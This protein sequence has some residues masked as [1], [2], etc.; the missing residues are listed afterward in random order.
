M[1]TQHASAH[2]FK[3]TVQ[4]GVQGT[5]LQLCL[6]LLLQCLG[7]RTPLLKLCALV[8]SGLRSKIHFLRA[9]LH[10]A[11]TLLQ[12][13]KHVRA[14]LQHFVFCLQARDFSCRCAPIQGLK[15]TEIK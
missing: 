12:L 5:L 4:G 3:R 10:I 15:F 7:I 13:F 9:L 11:Q 1:L 14:C 8:A 6:Q 2:G